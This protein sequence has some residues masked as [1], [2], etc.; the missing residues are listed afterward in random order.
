MVK[1]KRSLPDELILDV[2]V[3]RDLIHKEIVSE[4]QI[5]E[6]DL[7]NVQKLDRKLK[8][9]IRDKYD[10]VFDKIN[11]NRLRKKFRPSKERWWWFIDGGDSAFINKLN[12]LWITLIILILAI[13]V[14]IFSDVSTR[15]LSG[16]PNALVTF[17]IIVQAVLTLASAGTLTK[18]GR[19]FIDMVWLNL[20]VPKKHWKM[21]ELAYSLLSLLVLLN[22]RN[23]MPTLAVVFNNLGVESF[24]E[25]RLLDAR[26]NFE[27]SIKIDPNLMTA[28]FH[29]GRLYEEI[30]DIENARESYSIA[31]QG[32]ISFAYHHL[33]RLYI[34][35][36]ES[37]EDAENEYATAVFLLMQGL[38]IA[39]SDY[40]RFL[41]LK[42]L[43][44]AR[45]NQRRYEKAEAHLKGAIQAAPDEAAS[46]CLLAQV[47]DAKQNMSS[48]LPYWR[49][50]LQYASEC[51]RDEDRW[52]GLAHIR[53]GLEENRSKSCE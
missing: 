20:D 28:H 10:A 34:L 21:L 13:N 14:A 37:S 24:E 41:T 4:K 2:L 39:D 23:T 27:R 33:A 50:C 9:Q 49:Q 22:I 12:S 40:E 45:F 38:E 16:T 8:Y 48:S 31:A 32:G 26:N 29:M 46:Y 19:Q 52:V 5:R 15:I 1:K 17:S 51:K 42:S 3:L 6:E 43:G 47:L 36:G 30:Q 44:W 7:K 35:S 11:L 18:P 25:G 53:L